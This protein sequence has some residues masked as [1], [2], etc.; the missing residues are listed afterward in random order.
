MR[1]LL[2]WGLVA[3]AASLWRVRHYQNEKRTRGR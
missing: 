1:M 2:I 3:L